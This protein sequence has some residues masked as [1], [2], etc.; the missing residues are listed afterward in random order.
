MN[1]H[2]KAWNMD[3]LIYQYQPFKAMFTLYMLLNKYAC[4]FSMNVIW[5]SANEPHWALQL[6]IGFM[7]DNTSSESFHWGKLQ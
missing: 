2:S 1:H 4:H 7:Y 6:Y 5:F 3:I